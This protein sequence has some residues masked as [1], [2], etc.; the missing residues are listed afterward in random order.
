MYR[1]SVR[2]VLAV[3][4]LF[5]VPRPA[6]AQRAGLWE[7]LERLSGPGYFQGWSADI[8]V[9]FVCGWK[10][11]DSSVTKVPRNLL[12]RPFRDIPCWGRYDSREMTGP[13]GVSGGS[14]FFERRWYTAVRV[15]R[16][17][18]QA[19]D[20]PHFS[21]VKQG[22]ERTVVW[23]AIGA[24]VVWEPN[25][26]LDI[27][28]GGQFN[29]LSSKTGV[30]TGIS[31]GSF[32]LV[33]STVRPFA[34]GRSFLRDITIPVRFSLLA[35]KFDAAQFGA[36]GDF[37]SGPELQIQSGLTIDLGGARRY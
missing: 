10:E 4:C 9:P 13:G 15:L 22:I 17:T 16:A 8:P 35:H 12:V 25:R 32:E 36:I 29:H 11:L 3:L 30:F 1:I 33:G 7:W 6:L 14:I 21:Y 2:V 20:T 24:L 34:R 31:L 23:K 5:A 18:G 27:E 28:S 26:Y 19:S 37:Q